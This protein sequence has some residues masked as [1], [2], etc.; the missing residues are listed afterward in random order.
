MDFGEYTRLASANNIG[1]NLNSVRELK[2]A[3]ERRRVRS[4]DPA[5]QGAFGRDEE[6]ARRHALERAGKKLEAAGHTVHQVEDLLADTIIGI[7]ANY[8]KGLPIIASDR[9]LESAAEMADDILGY[10]RHDGVPLLPN[11][12]TPTDA[13]AKKALGAY[14]VQKE[15]LKSARE[16]REP[17]EV[18]DVILKTN[19]RLRGDDGVIPKIG[20]LSESRTSSAEETTESLGELQTDVNSSRKD[21]EQVK[22]DVVD[23]RLDTVSEDGDPLKGGTDVAS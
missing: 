20:E 11:V 5:R 1:L 15:A 22:R 4:K 6:P 8:S 10:A 19:E 3:Q 16:G 7:R 17:P 13:M 9:L 2:E 14:D 12:K 21:I 23:A 18:R